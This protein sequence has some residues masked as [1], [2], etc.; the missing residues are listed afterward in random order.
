MLEIL[1][2]IAIGSYAAPECAVSFERRESEKAVLALRP[3]CAIGHASTQAAIR[4]LLR[5][6]GDAPE[7]ALAL[8]RI[9]SHGWLSTMLARQASS[10]LRWNAAAGRPFA[11]GEN[12]YVAAALRGMPE[13]TALFAGWQ[14]AG[15]SVEKVLV[16]R[17]A[18]LSLPAGAPIS[19]ASLLPYDAILWVYLKK[20]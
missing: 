11:G 14:I 15:V 19:P 5:H 7:V 18:E 4:A 13:F 1:I 8:G 6:A 16:K 10:S 12:Q 3:S 9:E 20:L 2:A 17:A